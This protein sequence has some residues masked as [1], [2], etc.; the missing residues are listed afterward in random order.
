[1]WVIFHHSFAF[2]SLVFLICFLDFRSVLFYCR[3]SCKCYEVKTESWCHVYLLNYITC[4][5][6]WG[7][8]SISLFLF[9]PTN[10]VRG[11]LR[12]Q[13]IQCFA[14][15]I[16]LLQFCISF[17]IHSISIIWL[18]WWIGSYLPVKSHRLLCF[19]SIIRFFFSFVFVLLIAFLY[20]CRQRDCVWWKF[21][22]ARLFYEK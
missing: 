19:I 20:N 4:L 22:R 5:T 14:W 21:G 13:I 2:F 9:P 10:G 16:L 7:F 15:S 11:V 3:F 12:F 6:S 8:L 1:M 17:S 18:F